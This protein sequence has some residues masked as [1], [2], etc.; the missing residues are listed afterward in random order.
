MFNSHRNLLSRLGLNRTRQSFPL[1]LTPEQ[2]QVGTEL[3]A[4]VSD[5]SRPTRRLVLSNA[6]DDLF[7]P[8]DSQVNDFGDVRNR[9]FLDVRAP[10][11]MQLFQLFK[12]KPEWEKVG[13]S[14]KTPR[15]S[16][17]SF[18]DPGAK[19]VKQ[20]QTQGV[21]DALVKLTAGT[22]K[23]LPRPG[24]LELPAYLREYKASLQP[25]TPLAVRRPLPQNA[26]HLK[27]LG[28]NS[29]FTNGLLVH[30]HI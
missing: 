5:V 21:T 28:Y 6:R 26:S 8:Q 20:E 17:T 22:K 4:F 2:K 3:D 1:L 30:H 29:F 11:L 10:F 25:A 16:T 13:A 19:Q 14:Q 27:N 23:V 12:R 18:A 9:V 24:S 7:R 15:L